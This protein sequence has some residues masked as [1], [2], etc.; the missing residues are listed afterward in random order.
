MTAYL[1]IRAAMGPVAGTLDPY[2][3]LTGVLVVPFGAA[4]GALLARWVRWLVAVPVT[5]FLLAT[6]TWLN[7]NQGG[8][9]GWFLPVVLFSGPDWPARPSRLHV[10]YLLAAIALLAALTLLR[11][12][13]RPV[14]V[15]AAL[16]AAAAAVP[17]STS[18][19]SPPT[20]RHARNGCPPRSAGTT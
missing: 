19:A 16:T 2:E 12:G 18:C 3:A 9:G 5:M 20:T 8:Y 15:A 17:S 10:P 13:P 6:F 1:T 11:H 4:L 7:A 14:P